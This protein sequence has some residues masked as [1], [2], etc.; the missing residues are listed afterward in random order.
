MR[1]QKQKNSGL[2]KLCDL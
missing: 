2:A 1:I